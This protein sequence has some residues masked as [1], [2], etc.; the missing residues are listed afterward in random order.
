MTRSKPFP[1]MD[2]QVSRQGVYGDASQDSSD[3]E[4]FTMELTRMNHPGLYKST[5]GHDMSLLTTRTMLIECG[6]SCTS[7]HLY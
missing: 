3:V 1:S 4:R 2:I 7:F 5:Y 6:V